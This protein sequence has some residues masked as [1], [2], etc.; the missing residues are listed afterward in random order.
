MLDNLKLQ[1]IVNRD[2]MDINLVWDV[3]FYEKNIF[4]MPVETWML[5]SLTHVYFKDGKSK[6]FGSYN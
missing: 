1:D 2:H 5:N 3:D 6:I 4:K